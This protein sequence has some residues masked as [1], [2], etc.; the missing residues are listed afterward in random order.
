MNFFIPKI[1]KQIRD[2]SVM[3]T[4]NNDAHHLSV[5]GNILNI[6]G[7]DALVSD[8]PAMSIELDQMTS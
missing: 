7:L 4:P 5:L 1:G 6:F 2:P 8:D 3:T